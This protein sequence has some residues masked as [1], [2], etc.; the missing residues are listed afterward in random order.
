MSV[1]MV[2][3]WHKNLFIAITFTL[4]FGF[5]EGLY[6][7]AALIKF[8]EGAWVPIALSFILF[9]VMYI[10]HYGSVKKYEFDVQNKVSI[11]WL[12]NLGETLGITRVRGIGLIHTELV[13]GI[14]AIFYHFVTNLPAFHQVLVFLCVKSVPV[15]HVQPDERFLV[16]R[17]GPK[18][19]HIYRCIARYG[20]RDIHKDDMEFERDLICSIAEFI[21]SESTS[22]S[23]STFLVQ[24]NDNEKMTVVGTS[25]LSFTL[26]DDTVSTS[27]SSAPTNVTRKRVRFRLPETT[28]ANDTEIEDELNELADARESG[29]VFIM[30]HSYIKAKRGSGL[31]K[32]LVINYGYEFLRRNSRGPTYA[33]SIPRASTLEVGMAYHV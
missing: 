16:G 31:V 3:C 28:A 2:I 15:P 19:Y 4:F 29:M 25:N 27:T 24:D 1:V 11:N 12:L 17:V 9:T 18:E 8:L 14:P 6:F 7:S 30:G 23:T 20:Y 13:T 26:A 5:L 32:K 10:W 33:I 22:A 21:R